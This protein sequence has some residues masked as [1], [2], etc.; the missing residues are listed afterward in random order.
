[1]KTTRFAAVLAV[2]AATG[3]DLTVEAVE[4][5][6]RAAAAIHAELMA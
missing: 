1:M 2:A 5:G 4:D 3:R 6:K